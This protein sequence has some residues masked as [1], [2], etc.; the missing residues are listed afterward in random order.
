MSLLPTDTN[1]LQPSDRLMSAV[2][3]G[4]ADNLLAAL[5]DG[6]DP[7]YIRLDIAPTLVA[8]QR[9]FADCLAILVEHGGRADLPNRS[10]WTA[11]H[12]AATLEDPAFLD[13]ILSRPELV[14]ITVRE[15]DGQTA[16]RAA[17]DAGRVDNLKALLKV[18]STLAEIEDADGLSPLMAAAARRDEAS[19]R[20]LLAAGAD[21]RWT[22]MDGKSFAG[23]CTGWVV[24]ERLVGELALDQPAPRVAANA[25]ATED[26]AKTKESAEETAAPSNPFGLGGARR[27]KMG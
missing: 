21:P 6:A 15:R 12:E 24:G 2:S 11:L 5:A 22:N 10:G 14:R 19:V 13:S 17:I 23:L 27:R 26:T 8:V 4:Q 7:N 25:T 18:E 20:A 16:A 1:T 3:F 9:G